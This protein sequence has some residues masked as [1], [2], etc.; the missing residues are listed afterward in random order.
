MKTAQQIRQFIK[1]GNGRPPKG[2]PLHAAM[3]WGSQFRYS[4][5]AMLL[6]FASDYYDSDDYIRS[7]PQ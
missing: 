6:V 3:I 4:A 7:C 1:H 5:D 2:W